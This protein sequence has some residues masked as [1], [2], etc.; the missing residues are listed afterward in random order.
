MFIIR[1]LMLIR[2]IYS[3]EACHFFLNTFVATPI[4]LQF[5]LTMKVIHVV[6]GVQDFS[7]LFGWLIFISFRQGRP[8]IYFF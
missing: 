7:N 5:L 4:A 1:L 2:F 8:S 6:K 3:A